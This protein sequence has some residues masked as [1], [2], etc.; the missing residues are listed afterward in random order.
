MPILTRCLPRMTQTGA[1]QM[2]KR[3]LLVMASCSLIQSMAWSA[4]REN[5]TVVA[6]SDVFSSCRQAKACGATAVY[7]FLKLHDIDSHYVQ[8]LAAIPLGER[9]SNFHDLADYCKHQGLAVKIIALAAGEMNAY[10]LPLI[11]HLKSSDHSVLRN[12]HRGHFI[13]VLRVDNRTITF[14]DPSSTSVYP[15]QLSTESFERV[16]SG[17][18]LVR[19]D[20]LPMETAISIFGLAAS[21]ALAAVILKK[22]ASLL[23]IGC[24]MAVGV[25]CNSPDEHAAAA[26]AGKLW[27]TSNEA[28]L[29]LLSNEPERN[30]ARFTIVNQ[31]GETKTLQLG[32]PSCVC[33]HADVAPLIVGPGEKALVSMSVK[34]GADPGPVRA[35]LAVATEDGTWSDVFA[36]KGFARGLKLPSRYFVAEGRQDGLI[37]GDVFTADRASSWN[38][39]V[40]AVGDQGRLVVL[41][42]YNIGDTMTLY[43]GKYARAEVTIPFKVRPREIASEMG[44]SAATLRVS[45]TGDKSEFVQY[46]TVVVMR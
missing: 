44:V 4:E 30:V 37:R 11:A 15:Q 19:S 24:L 29:G 21:F 32:K 17:Y 5:E 27:A 39:R 43:D 40:E 7:T 10:R 13:T 25:G 46:V 8:V 1:P 35:S 22:N 6:K 45:L 36:V 31:T 23:A 2:L 38:L 20:A 41:G 28:D 33:T 14:L 12:Y 42:S 18:S 3:F 26:D 16:Y 9:G 34:A